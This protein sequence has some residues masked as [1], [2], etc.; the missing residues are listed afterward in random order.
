MKRASTVLAFLAALIC[1]CT[2]LTSCG[3]KKYAGNAAGFGGDVVAQVAVKD[4]KI[5]SIVVTG[6][7]ETA[8]IGGKALETL[9]TA[10][11]QYKGT[12]LAALNVNSLDTVSGATVTSNAVKAAF[13]DVQRQAAGTAGRKTAVADGTYTA[14][15]VSYSVTDMMTLAVTFK[16]NA[17][18]AIDTINA[19]STE[20]IYPSMANNLFPRIIASQNIGVDAIAGATVSSNAAKQAIAETITAAGGDPSEWSKPVAKVNK[21]VKLEGYDTIV[22]GLGG[23][24]VMAYL[25]ATE[26]G[27]TVFGI[28]KAA[29]VG[30]NAATT[31]GPMAVNPPSYV[32][33]NGGKFVEESE[34]IEDWYNYTEGDSKK[35]IIEL[36]VHESGKT[37]DWMQDNYDFSFVPGLMAFFDPHNW[38]VWT[39]YGGKNGA[40][41][42]VGYENS[43][44]MAKA[45]NPKNDYMTELCAD[46]LIMDKDGTIK[47]VRATYYDGTTY[48]IYGD[49]V[50]LATGGFIGNAEMCKKYVGGVWKTEAMTQC[51]G[52]GIIMG[53]SA[54][55]ALFNPDVAAIEHIAHLDTIIRN[56][57]LTKD[58][59]AVLVSLVLDS[60]DYATMSFPHMIL[61]T[62]GDL[63]NGKYGFFAFDTWKA[64]PNFYTIYTQ[65]DMDAI[66]ANGL[67]R[68]NAPTFMG[69]G[70]EAKAG[71]P[72]DSLDKILTVGESYGDVFKGTTIAELAQKTGLSADAV[73]AAAAAYHL[74]ASSC[75]YAI[76]GASYVYST[77]GGLDIDENCN[78]VKTDGTV[79]PNLFAIGTD[80]MGTMFASNKAYVAYGGAAQGWAL[81]SGRLVGKTV[82]ERYK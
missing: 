75:Y 41:K 52:A 77:S 72:V 11:A 63:F 27:A 80:S 57:D 2:V 9:N 30:G 45:R 78:V 35:E 1:L 69:Q 22:V 3:G 14:T 79:I 21:T 71:V 66:K 54:G 43:M 8:A 26:N 18:T 6:E 56:D 81:T 60:I 67:A 55:G 42:T 17:I 40:S 10:L 13:K 15:V 5:T 25:S 12:E 74:P 58:E 65:E 32:Q 48:E 16:D 31:S 73:T 46:E 70:G 20:D 47:G 33:A 36:F 4:G 82:A 51:D 59:K 7:K 62:N 39:P 49:S 28:E 19:G 24:G 61:D 44:K 38:Q 37:L 34:L 64:G 29:K 53:Q 76:K 68:V 23:A 50:I